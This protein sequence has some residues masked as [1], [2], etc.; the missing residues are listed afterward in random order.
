[1]VVIKF[2]KF[3]AIKK[4]IPIRVKYELIRLIEFRFTAK[5]TRYAYKRGPFSK[6]VNSR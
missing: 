2:Q 3:L 5:L 6:C 1:M 4:D